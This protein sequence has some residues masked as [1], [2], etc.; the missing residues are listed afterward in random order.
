[1]SDPYTF[2]PLLLLVV[3]FYLLVLRP[4]RARQREFTAT[5]QALEPGSRVMLASG[6]YGDIATIGDETIELEVSPGMHVTVAR[7][8]VARVLPAPEPVD[9][10][11]SPDASE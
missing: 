7:Q 6:I 11:T 2:I 10:T 5:Q 9:P 8:A 1:M 4:A 3:V